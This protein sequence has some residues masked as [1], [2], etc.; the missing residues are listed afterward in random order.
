MPE[1]PKL[2]YPDLSYKII[3]ILFEVFNELDY[4]YKEVYYQRA[5]AK[6]FETLGIEFRE[7]VGFP[8]KF[9]G[10]E[11]GRGMCDF[12]IENKVILEIKRGDRFSAQDIKQTFTYLKAN[13]LKLGIVA[14]FSSKGLK[15][16]RV[17]NTY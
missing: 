4:S 8:L 16:K 10:A 6:S 13:N 12:L 15:F 11:I 17:L 14:R 7:Q 2:I 9:K 3:G 5:I 1:K